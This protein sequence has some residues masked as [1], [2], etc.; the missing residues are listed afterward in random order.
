MNIQTATLDEL[1]AFIYSA[2]SPTFTTEALKSM[3]KESGDMLTMFKIEIA[4][5][6][7]YAKIA[8]EKMEDLLE[9]YEKEHNNE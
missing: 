3:C 7:V 8:L 9:Q 4:E 5:Q 6:S 1:S 2:D